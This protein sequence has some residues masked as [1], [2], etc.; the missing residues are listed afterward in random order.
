MAR[1]IIILFIFILGIFFLV[2]IFA[3][4]FATSV[5]PG[6]HTTILAPQQLFGCRY[7]PAQLL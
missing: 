5:I 7:I 2:T 4:D 6:W 1:G 3:F